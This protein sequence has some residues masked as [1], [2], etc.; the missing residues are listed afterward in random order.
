MYGV[1]VQ[2]LCYAGAR[3]THKIIGHAGDETQTLSGNCI[4][5]TFL[6]VNLLRQ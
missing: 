1:Y 6:T 2:V 5:D 3:V 4:Y